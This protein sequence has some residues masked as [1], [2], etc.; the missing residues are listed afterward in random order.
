MKKSNVKRINSGPVGISIMRTNKTLYK[1]TILLYKIVLAFGF[2]PNPTEP[3][4]LQTEKY[5]W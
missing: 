2:G 3:T 5:A 4:L 1:Q